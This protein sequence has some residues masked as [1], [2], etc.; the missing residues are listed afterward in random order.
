M[1][2][3]INNMWRYYLSLEDDISNTSR[4]VEPIGQEDVF[5]LE[6]AKILIL[7]CVEVESVLKK[8]YYF[9]NPSRSKKSKLNIKD[10]KSV[11]TTKCPTIAKE[12]LSVSRTGK[13][14]IPFQSWDLDEDSPRWWKAYQDV[15]HNR[16]EQYKNASYS[17]A[18]S[19]LAALHIL[20]QYLSTI[21][22]TD[23]CNVSQYI[24]SDYSLVY[25]V[26]L[27]GNEKPLFSK[28]IA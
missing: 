22:G 12:S 8:F 9:Y 19:A 1:R 7:S 4:F 17:N 21:T 18:V 6:F 2:E 28:P 20:I 13:T 25:G 3:E 15:K 27:S 5:S 26:A 16:F 24:K 10:Y 11:L 14:I 23:F